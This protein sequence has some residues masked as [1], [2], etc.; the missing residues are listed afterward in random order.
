MGPYF[1]KLSL[2]TTNRKIWVNADKII[3]IVELSDGT[4]RI[5]FAG[6]PRCVN[7]TPEE[8]L[9]LIREVYSA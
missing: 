9:K 4:S 3:A 6:D 8:I 5:D 2:K 1:I 7:E